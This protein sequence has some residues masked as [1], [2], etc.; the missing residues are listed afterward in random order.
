MNPGLVPRELSGTQLLS[1]DRGKRPGVG[2]GWYLCNFRSLKSST[3]CVWLS[4]FWPV[5]SQ[6]SVT[7]S[8]KWE[9]QIIAKI[10]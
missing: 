7:M 8:T 2:R 6:A 3:R 4:C 1:E 5:T 9:Q 10:D